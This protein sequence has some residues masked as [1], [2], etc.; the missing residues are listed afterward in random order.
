ML[1]G[2]PKI[3]QCRKPS[4]YVFARGH[5][6]LATVSWRLLSGRLQDYSHLIVTVLWLLGDYL[7]SVTRRGCAKEVWIAVLGSV[8]S[9]SAAAARGPNGGIISNRSVLPRKSTVTRRL[10]PSRS[11]T[12]S[13]RIT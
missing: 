12:L 10:L 13:N 11:V 5:A 2:V 6:R 9:V 8:S 3:L 1:S 7:S 4:L